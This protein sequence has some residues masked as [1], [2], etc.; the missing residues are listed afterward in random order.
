MIRKTVLSI[1][2]L[3][4]GGGKIGLYRDLQALMQTVNDFQPEY[5]VYLAGQGMVTQSWQTS[6]HW[7]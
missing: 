5:V 7:Y 1:F 2:A 4:L 6:V 3:S